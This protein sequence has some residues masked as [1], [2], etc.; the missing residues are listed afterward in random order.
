MGYLPISEDLPRGDFFALVCEGDSM[1]DIGISSGDVVYVRR[2]PSAD[3]G[4]IVVAMLFDEITG[5]PR[6][7]LKRFFR[8]PE[9][10]KF[11]LRPENSLMRDIVT[12]R[13]EILGVAYRVLKKLK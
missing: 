3:D 11:I 9:K 4:D 1:I 2:Q 12:D 8:T 10:K 7:T 13:V 6:A 5:E